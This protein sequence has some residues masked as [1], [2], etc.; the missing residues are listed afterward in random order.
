MR[1]DVVALL[2]PIGVGLTAR[3]LLLLVVCFVPCDTRNTLD[4]VLGHQ[5][6][7]DIVL[8]AGDVSYA[9]C[10]QVGDTQPLQVCTT[11]QRHHSPVVRPKT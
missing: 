4:A 1:G 10:K 6:A 5:P 8:H 2:C 3:T 9:D 7:I 11:L